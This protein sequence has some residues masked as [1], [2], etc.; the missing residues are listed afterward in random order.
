LQPSAEAVLD[1]YEHPLH[2][3]ALASPPAVSASATNPR[4]GDEVQMY[5]EVS[6][7]RVVRASFDG[8]GCTISQAAADVAAELAESRPVADVLRLQ[9]SDVLATLG[10]L[11]TRLD[12][13]ALGLLTLQRALLQA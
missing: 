1:R 11:R 8:A 13:A 9:L 7:G 4:C 10:P 5:A 2:R 12:C 3:G 6:D